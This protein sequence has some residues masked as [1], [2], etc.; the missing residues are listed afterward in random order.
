MSHPGS[1]IEAYLIGTGE[2][3]SNPYLV[4]DDL[5][6]INDYFSEEKKD[7]NIDILLKY[8]SSVMDRHLTFYGVISILRKIVMPNY[9]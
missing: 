6:E 7:T 1:L 3:I 9:N 5:I 8:W 2:T 4:C